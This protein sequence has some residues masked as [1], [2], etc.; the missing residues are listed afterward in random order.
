MYACIE[1]FN[2]MQSNSM[3]LRCM[4]HNNT[5]SLYCLTERRILCV[6]C[7]FGVT[8]HRTHKIMPLRD[9]EN[10]INEDN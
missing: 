7:I 9:S 10:Y 5:L 1:L 6:N 4:K 3:Q 2:L 8:K